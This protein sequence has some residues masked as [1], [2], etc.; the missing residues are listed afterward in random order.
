M[1]TSARFLLLAICG[2]VTPCFAGDLN[3]GSMLSNGQINGLIAYIV[4]AHVLCI[5]AFIVKKEWLRVTAGVLYAAVFFILTGLCLF[6][7]IF[8]FYFLFTGAFFTFTIII[9]RK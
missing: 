7:P 4:F 8:A 9:R 2:T 6:N 5:A 1:S 3:M